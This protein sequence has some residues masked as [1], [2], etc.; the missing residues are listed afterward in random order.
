MFQIWIGIHTDFGCLDPDA[1]PR[2]RK[3]PSKIEKSEEISS[4]EVLDVLF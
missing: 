2:G 3:L 4:F 1:D